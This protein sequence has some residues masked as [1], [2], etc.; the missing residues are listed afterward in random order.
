MRT[1]LI[2]FPAPRY[3]PAQIYTQT[4]QEAKRMLE[5]PGK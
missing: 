4:P 5:M 3:L 2:V 1:D